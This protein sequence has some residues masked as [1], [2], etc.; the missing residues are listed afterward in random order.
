MFT[1]IIHNLAKLINKQKN[2]SGLDFTFNV[3]K[4][5]IEGIKLGDS[6][7][8]NGCCLSVSKIDKESLTIEFQISPESICKTSLGDIEPNDF[9]NVEKALCLQDRLDGHLVTGHI[10]GVAELVTFEEIENYFK[11]SFVVDPKSQKDIAPFLVKKGSVCINGI[12]LTVNDVQDIDDKTEFSVMLIPITLAKTSLTNIV[13]GAKVN[14]ETD[15]LAK[16]F[17]RYKNFG[18]DF[19]LQTSEGQ[20]YHVC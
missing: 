19:N 15:I 2:G 10:D 3:T 20:N 17:I 12:S 4:D 8:V 9:V 7:S 11:Y 1:G 5:F 13:K 6:I 14:I 16:H 18:N